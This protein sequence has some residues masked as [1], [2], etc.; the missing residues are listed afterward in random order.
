MPFV[1]DVPVGAIVYLECGCRG[2]RM[3]AKPDAPKI[4]VIVSYP[5]AQHG[6]DISIRELEAL[7]SVGAFTKST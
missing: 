1:Q 7:T 3:P 4:L 2:H 6:P 5:C